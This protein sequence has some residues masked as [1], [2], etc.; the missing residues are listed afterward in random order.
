MRLPLIIAGVLGVIALVVMILLLRGKN[1]SDTRP[2]T[3]LVNPVSASEIIP[4][5]VPALPTAL[6]GDKTVVVWSAHAGARLEPCGCVAG[7]HGG[8]VRRASLVARVA[9]SR[10]LVLEC[11]G[12]S[13]GAADYQQVRT[14]TYL[15]ALQQTTQAVVGIGT[16]EVKLGS[17]ILTTFMHGSD[18]PTMVSAN[19]SKA[20]GSPLGERSVRIERSGQ[21]FVVTS[22]APAS[23]TGTGLTVSDP[24]Q[25]ILKIIAQFPK[26]SVVVMADMDEVAL[27]AFAR[28]VP[29]ISLLVG[30]AVAGPSPQPLSVGPTR[31]VHV[32][33]EG[34]TIGYWLWGSDV[35]H[36]D[37]VDDKVP[38]HP[39]V[40]SAIGQYQELLGSM[41]LV[42]DERLAG[43]TTLQRDDAARYVGNNSCLVC[44]ATAHA[45]HT[46]SKHAHAYESLVKKGYQ[47]DPDCLRC[48]VV[49]PGLPDGFK[50]RGEPL[51][52][53]DAIQ[54]DFAQVGCESCHGRGSNHVAERT[55]GQI[56]SGSLQPVTPA[57]C[58]RCHD[59]ENSPRFNYDKYWEII[60]HGR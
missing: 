31:L 42:I 33:N 9:A 17:T 3:Q 52:Q 1:N 5:G 19:V 12:W 54:R 43:M 15:R 46:L 48:H 22:V 29:G 50:R 39:L 25:A 45:R 10:R 57:T 59:L 20:D 32:A 23:A 7:M 55:N 8:L 51:A 40:R 26:T 53:R 60:R 28:A 16:A 47:H 36:Y 49:G 11:G 30:G 44:H 14:A 24:E 37:L 56:S 34:K 41:D 18:F 13:G 58:Q 4:A 38:D 6:V 21:I 27:M 35:C 2:K